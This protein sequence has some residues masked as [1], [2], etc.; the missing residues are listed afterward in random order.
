MRPAD[1]NHVDLTTLL[2]AVRSCTIC[3]DLPLG[4]RPILQGS[5]KAK[6]LIVGQA[7]GR[8]THKKGI[9]FD[10]PS[11]KRLRAWMGVTEDVF[12]NP[13]KIAILPMGFCF[14]GTG[15]SGDLPP[16][17]E[18]ANAWRRPLLEHLSHI[19]VTLI[20][21]QYAINWHINDGQKA[22]LTDRV[23]NW[24]NDMPSRIVMPHPS[25]RNNRWL[26]RNPWFET[27]VLPALKERIR[28]ILI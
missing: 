14:P 8:V 13:D 10:D 5:T 25:P 1:N 7:P 12:Y 24:K 18:C 11:G 20:I 21:G 2:E 28:D 26:K 16:R 17:S 6:V 9:P 15:N 19:E 4:P 23:S 3:E 27:D 22:N